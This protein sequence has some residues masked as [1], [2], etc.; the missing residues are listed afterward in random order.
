MLFHKYSIIT[1][2]G[3]SA[4]LFVISLCACA[5]INLGLNQNVTLIE[6]SDLFNYFTHLDDYGEVGPPAYIVFKNVDYE[7][8]ENVELLEELS[9]KVS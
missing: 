2:L 9:D 5:K 4:M 8:E 6:G 3:T 7:D 1:V